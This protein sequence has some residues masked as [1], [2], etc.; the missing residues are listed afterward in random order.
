MRRA[1]SFGFDLDHYPDHDQG[2]HEGW[3]RMNAG[4]GSGRRRQKGEIDRKGSTLKSERGGQ[5]ARRE[6]EAW[7]SRTR[8]RNSSVSR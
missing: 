3:G 2:R 8:L 5:P 4:G 7:T 1:G 6:C